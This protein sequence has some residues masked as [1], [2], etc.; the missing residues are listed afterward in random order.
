MKNPSTP[1]QALNKAFLKLKPT[2]NEINLFKDNFSRLLGEIDE[3]EDEEF[4]KNLVIKFLRNTYYKNDFFINTNKN[5]DQVI[6][7]AETNK[8]PVA[9]IIEAKKPND[10]SGMI[11]VAKSETMQIKKINKKALQQLVLYFLRERITKNN[12]SLTHIIAT[13]INEWFIFDAQVFDKVFAQNK[14]L[15]KKF[16]EFEKKNLSGTTTAFFYKNIAKPFIANLAAEDLPFTHFDIQTY[17]K[18]LESKDREE[19]LKL[20]AL[21]KLF[22]PAHL[23]KRPFANDSN[24]LDQQFYDELLHILGL[25]EVKRK[26]KKLIER[27]PKG[28]RQQGSLLENAIMQ[29]ESADAID[30]AKSN[31]TYDEMA[32]EIG[33]ELCITWINRILFLKLLESQLIGYHKASEAKAYSF[34]NSGKIKNF[35]DLNTLFFQVLAKKRT[36]RK[37]SINKEFEKVPY[38]NSSLFEQTKLE[39]NSIFI[40]NL[41]NKKTLDIHHKTALKD[42]NSKQQTGD[43]N[44]LK[45][46]FAFLDAYD[47]SSEGTENIQEDNKRL[48]NA[49][50]LGLIFEKINGYQDGSFFTPSFITM[51]MCRETLRRSVVQKFNEAKK[52]NCQTLKDVYNNIKN[53]KEANKIINSITICDPAVGSGHFL[54][55][56]LNELIAIKSELHLLQDENGRRLKD[57]TVEVVNDELVVTDEYGDF[58]KY[59][60]HLKESQRVQKTLFHEKKSIIENCLFGVDI[61]IN[62]VKICRLRLWIEL[63][64]N[65]YYKNE[66]DLETLPNIDINIK[67]GNSLISRFALDADLSKALKKS[68][69]TIGTYRDAV[70]SYHKETNSNNKRQLLR[71]IND[72]KNSFST[73]IGRNGKEIMTLNRLRNEHYNKYVGGNMFGEQKLTKAA[74]KKRDREQAK[75]E[76]KIEQQETAIEDIKTN[77]IYDNAFEW[78]FEFPEVLNKKGDFVGFDAIVGNPPYIQIESFKGNPIQAY[79][80]KQGFETFKGNADIYCLFYEKGMQLLKPKGILNFITSNKWMRTK[81]GEKTRNFFTTKTN[82]ILLIDFQ[83]VE[84]FE[85]ATLD[86]NILMLEKDNYKKQIL[87]CRFNKTFNQKKDDIIDFIINN[88]TIVGFRKGTAAWVLLNKQAQKIKTKVEKVGTPLKDW[89]ININRGITT[90]FNEA[91]IISGA[92][93]DELIQADAKN[94]EIIKPILR[95]RNIKKYQA[96]FADL[97]IICTFPAKKT[98]VDN[99]PSVKKYLETFLPKLKQTGENYI[100]DGVAKKT[101]KKT[102]NK[103]FETQDQIAYF[104]E[105]EKS[106]IIYPNMTK[107]MPFI[108]DKNTHYFCNDKAFIITGHSLEY[109]VAFFNSKLFKFCFKD[110]FPE[111]KGGTR[112]LRKVFF[113]KIPVKQISKTAQ[114]PFIT[115]V[116]KIISEK[117]LGKDT[118]KLE[119][120]LDK[121]IYKLYNLTAEE[122]ALIENS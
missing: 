69:W 95:G 27:L 66:Y 56:A 9:V 4:H 19:E 37:D 114:K 87:A 81:Y 35:N 1:R 61:N 100:E 73:S 7:H 90:G 39:K 55:S 59:R 57:Y 10:K 97:Y 38:L 14:S 80:A 83:G 13:N 116:E 105:F 88:Q 117:A 92:K 68:K 52:W 75:L 25:T 60:P 21:Y 36:D 49:S 3:K 54:V 99:Y 103:W 11:Q 28:K 29:L 53:K 30:T 101:R 8:S 24:T 12:V 23:L 85:S 47:F 2:R 78:R 64:K 120:A 104:K 15:V 111:L 50:V 76:Q 118:S 65:A 43:M 79:W 5:K 122:I 22:S 110:N 46:L 44:T 58:V 6:H 91:F 62:S 45:Y 18:G 48:I 63:L 77:K 67:C 20:I 113:D 96:E 74:Q 16:Q 41:D 106:K 94:A 17:K 112:E 31:K 32:F 119:N 102:G 72:I 109:L 33:I 98:N 42:S 82:P 26:G 34:L 51:Y 115:K 86:A 71:L 84:I 40:S 93:K 89:N 121:M 70:V 108:Y 107:Y